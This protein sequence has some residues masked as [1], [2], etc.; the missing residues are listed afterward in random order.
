M[1]KQYFAKILS[2]GKKKRVPV[3]KTFLRVRWSQM[4]YMTNFHRRSHR[5]E[6]KKWG[7][8]V[9]S[10]SFIQSFDHPEI[11]FRL[12]RDVIETVEYGKI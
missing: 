8:K 10:R 3:N 5:K 1:S 11:E 4:E 9:Q 2:K 7:A 12:A 6:L